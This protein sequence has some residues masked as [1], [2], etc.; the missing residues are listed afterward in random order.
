VFDQLGHPSES[1]SNLL[2]KK[3]VFDKLQFDLNQSSFAKPKSIFDRIQLSEAG[4]SLVKK[5]D[6]GKAA[7]SEGMEL[8]KFKFSNSMAAN[9][10][11][12]ASSGHYCI[13]C[14]CVG[15]LRSSCRYS[16]TYHSCN[17][18]EHIASNCRGL[19]L[20]K[21]FKPNKSPTDCFERK[22]LGQ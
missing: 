10:K 12:G 22:D 18:P 3:L 15:H 7:F 6:Q 4:S 16:I 2:P 9:F 17:R 14:L 5:P 13:R 11:V 8:S 20:N 19:T 21:G 1:S